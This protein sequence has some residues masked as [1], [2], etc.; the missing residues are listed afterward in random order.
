MTALFSQ[1]QR[2]DKMDRFFA[3]VASLMS[4]LLRSAVENSIY[5]LVDLLEQY[6][7]GNAFEGEYDLFCNLAT[8][9][10][11]HL[12]TLFLVRS[13]NIWAKLTN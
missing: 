6:S 1:D 8:P 11:I 10:K 4:V 7:E 12:I 13:I 2:L 3:S 9:S 5:D